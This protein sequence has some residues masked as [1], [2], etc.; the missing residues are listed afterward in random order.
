MVAVKDGQVLAHIPLPVGGLM[1]LA[2][3]E[4]MAALAADFRRAIGQLGL[5]VKQPIL[6]FAVFSLGVGPGLKITDRGV[7]DNSSQSLIP[8]FVASEGAAER[9]G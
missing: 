3:L 6:P 4:E 5:D 9:S 8:L 1:A 7:W 2:N